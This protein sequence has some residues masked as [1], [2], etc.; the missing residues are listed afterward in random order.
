MGEIRTPP[1][2][3]RVTYFCDR[4]RKTDISIDAKIE[5]MDRD[6]QGAVVYSHHWHLCQSCRSDFAAWMKEGA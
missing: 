3:E 2:P 6:F 1:T 4:C 5:T